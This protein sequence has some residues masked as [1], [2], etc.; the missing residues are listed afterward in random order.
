MENIERLRSF[1]E[2]RFFGVCSYLGD[3]LSI[4]S[5]KIRLFFIYAT[6]VAAGSPVIIYLVLAFLIKLK[7]YIKGK[8]NTV[9]DF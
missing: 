8:R 1:I 9:W 7:D 5:G 6:F 3:K 2:P 4:P